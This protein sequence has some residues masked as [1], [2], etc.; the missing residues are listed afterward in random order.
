M[1]YFKRK[2]LTVKKYNRCAIFIFLFFLMPQYLIS[3]GD[4]TRRL[5]TDPI[6]SD[7]VFSKVLE[8]DSITH[9]SAFKLTS[10]HISPAIHPYFRDRYRVIQDMRRLVQIFDYQAINGYE[11][12]NDLVD[13][14]QKFPEPTQTKMIG[15]AMAGSVVNLIS[16]KTN[17][18]LKKMKIHFLQW[19]SEKVIFQNRFKYI[20]INIHAGLNSR[21]IGFYFPMF[22]INYYLYYTHYCKN[23]NITFYP[24][25]KLGLSFSRWNGQPIITSSYFSPIGTFALSYDDNRKIIRSRFD[26]RKSSTVI[27]RIV[28]INYLK[29]INADRLLS[30]LLIY[31]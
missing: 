25:R 10:N 4:S 18:Q 31:W 16:E 19:R 23:E 27:I 1:H 22:R 29:R 14:C 24:K 3:S 28:H 17:K 2:I 8:K 21:G 15:M 7:S 6:V 30:E 5:S 20:L 26:I 12:I 9:K 13:I 11:S